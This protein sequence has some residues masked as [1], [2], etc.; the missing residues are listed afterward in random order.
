MKKFIVGVITGILLSSSIAFAATYVANTA[1]FKVLVNGE[2]FVSDPPALV[3]EGRTY[4]P[5]RAIGD[6]L[7]VPVNWNEE[8][9]QAEVGSMPEGSI[10]HYLGAP[11]SIDLGALLGIKP[12]RSNTEDPKAQYHAYNILDLSPKT[13]EIYIKAL[14]QEGYVAL[15][16][17]AESEY[18]YVCRK[19]NTFTYIEFDEGEMIIYTIIVD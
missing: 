9:R 18:E 15:P 8:L 10:P 17:S 1:S 4:L 14:A 6:A 19:G 16:Q 3:V 13:L 12:L 5:L 2:E 7:G 11:D